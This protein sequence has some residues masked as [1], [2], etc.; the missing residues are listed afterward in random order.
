MQVHGP[1]G[2]SAGPGTPVW[3]DGAPPANSNQYNRW[4]LATLFTSCAWLYC[5]SFFV[6]LSLHRLPAAGPGSS[7]QANVHML[8][9]RTATVR[10]ASARRRHLFERAVRRSPHPLQANGPKEDAGFP[11]LGALYALASRWLPATSVAWAAAW[12]R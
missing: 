4:L 1:M 6:C 8:G 12:G 10:Y 3:V 7:S 11:T 9:R 2:G 5:L